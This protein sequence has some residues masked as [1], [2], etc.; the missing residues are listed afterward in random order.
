MSMRLIQYHC[1][2][3]LESLTTNPQANYHARR[4]MEITKEDTSLA[5]RRVAEQSTL[6][7]RIVKNRYRI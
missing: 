2:R 1:G 7:W 6:W 5:A 4:I 3:L